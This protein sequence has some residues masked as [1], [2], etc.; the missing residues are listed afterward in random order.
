MYAKLEGIQLNKYDRY[1]MF[2]KQ[3]SEARKDNLIRK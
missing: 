1:K 2:K 3:T